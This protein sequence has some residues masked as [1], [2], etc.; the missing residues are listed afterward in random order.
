MRI[1]IIGTGTHGSRYAN[2]LVHDIDGLQLVAISRR[3]ASGEAQA[4]EWQCRWHRDWQQL[5]ADDQVE[6]VISVVP[7]TLNLAIARSC[8]AHNKPLLLE[9]PLADTAASGQEIVRLFKEQNLPLTTGQTLRYNQVIQTFKKQ[10]PELGGLHSFACNQRLEPSTL[11]W[12]EQP[13][14]AGA[15]VSFHTAVHV[16]DALR[17][18]TGLEIVRVMAVTGSRHNAALEDLLLVLVELENRVLGSVDCSKVGK[19]R[20]GRYEFV[21]DN[22]QLVGDQVHNQCGLIRG[23]DIEPVACG[24]PVGTIIPLLRDWQR[25]LSGQGANPISG[26]DGLRAVQACEACLTSARQSCWVDVGDVG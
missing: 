18:I 6:A 10:L 24:Q 13:E 7:P 9:K 1:G 12:H 26:A 16:F 5:V 21:C 23:M 25:F 19:A 8:A 2:H 4:R 22:G 20:S 15:G 3:S 17:F 11:G 14:L